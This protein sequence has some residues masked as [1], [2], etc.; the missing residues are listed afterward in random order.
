MTFKCHP[1][2]WCTLCDTI[3]RKD[4]IVIIQYVGWAIRKEDCMVAVKR[5]KSWGLNTRGR[6]IPQRVFTQAGRRHQRWNALVKMSLFTVLIAIWDCHWGFTAAQKFDAE[7]PVSSSQASQ[8]KCGFILKYSYS[9]RQQKMEKSKKLAGLQTMGCIHFTSAGRVFSLS[10]GWSRV[11]LHQNCV[12]QVCIPRH[13]YM[14]LER[15]SKSSK[16]T[17]FICRFMCFRN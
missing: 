9:G 10:K 11:L 16:F 6:P 1:R 3:L 17:S 2:G 12:G 5:L 14:N 4:Q 7:N 8:C 13:L 15:W